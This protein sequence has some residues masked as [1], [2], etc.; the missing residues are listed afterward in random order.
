MIERTIKEFWPIGTRVRIKGPLQV[1]DAKMADRLGSQG[2]VM[3]RGIESNGTPLYVVEFDDGRRDQIP[4]ENTE[5]SEMPKAL[6]G[7]YP[8][9]RLDREDFPT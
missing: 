5:A 1:A 8:G 7:L 2:V 3:G 9:E 4:S 6:A